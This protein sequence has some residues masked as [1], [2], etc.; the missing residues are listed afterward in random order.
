MQ[1]LVGVTINRVTPPRDLQNLGRDLN[2]ALAREEAREYQ[3]RTDYSKLP[4]TVAKLCTFFCRIL[5]AS[6]GILP[7]RYC[8]MPR[9]AVE[10]RISTRDEV[11]VG[12]KARPPIT[13]AGH[14]AR[15]SD[16]A[17][18][19]PLADSVPNFSEHTELTTRRIW[20][21]T[22]IWGTQKQRAMLSHTNRS[23]GIHASGRGSTM[24]AKAASRDCII[25][26]PHGY[27]AI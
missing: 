27:L 7:Q 19:A 20:P 24:T 1:Q 16:R 4:V 25:S 6:G 13:Y 9:S 14:P 5:K 12:R 21:R 8:N 10:I 3:R 11:A 2:K 18:V 15:A 26:Y 23:R 17:S 22:P